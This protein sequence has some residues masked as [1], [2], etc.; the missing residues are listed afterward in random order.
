MS[1]WKDVLQKQQDDLERLEA[2]DRE[3]GD[4]HSSTAAGVS[5]AL[6]L[7]TYWYIRVSSEPPQPASFSNFFPMLS[8][9]FS[10]LLPIQRPTVCSAAIQ[11]SE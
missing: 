2:M 8:P 4:A 10:R 6:S 3:L 5:S 1:S 7:S 11:T 9:L